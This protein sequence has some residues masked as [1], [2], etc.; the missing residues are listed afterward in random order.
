MNSRPPRPERRP[1][2]PSCTAACWQVPIYLV[3]DIRSIDAFQTV[4]ASAGPYGSQH[5][6][7]HVASPRIHL[8]FGSYAGRIEEPAWKRTI[9]V[10]ARG[11]SALPD[12]A[13]VGAST[14]IPAPSVRPLPGAPRRPSVTGDLGFELCGSILRR[15]RVIDRCNRVPIPALE[16]RVTE[17]SSRRQ[18]AIELDA[19]GGLGVVAGEVLILDR[20]ENTEGND[21][22]QHDQQSGERRR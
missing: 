19:Q 3:F 13:M 9:R 18:W 10:C 8:G 5:G 15:G 16:G 17:G 22:R 14:Q 6:S 20:G 1:T 7:Q 11:W 21:Y 12:R 4:S 2:S